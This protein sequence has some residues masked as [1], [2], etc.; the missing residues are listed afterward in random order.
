MKGAEKVQRGYGDADRL[1]TPEQD[2][3]RFDR[4]MAIA[5]EDEESAGAV[6]TILSNNF[7]GPRRFGKMFP[8]LSAFR[9]ADEGLIELGGKMKEA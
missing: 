8:D 3:Q 7:T 1:L 9:P 6:R 4:I 5:A 2:L